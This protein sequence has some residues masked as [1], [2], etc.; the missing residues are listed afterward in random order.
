MKYVSV[1]DNAEYVIFLRCDLELGDKFL[2]LEADQYKNSGMDCAAYASFRTSNESHL[3][4][5]R[6]RRLTV[7]CACLRGKKRPSSSNVQTS[8]SSY[9]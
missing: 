3:T 7:V 8:E 5:Y 1:E 9:S 6:F 2:S 4:G